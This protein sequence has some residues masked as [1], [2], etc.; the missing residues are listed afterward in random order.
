MFLLTDNNNYSTSPVCL[1]FLQKKGFFK[2]EKNKTIRVHWF[3]RIFIDTSWVGCVRLVRLIMTFLWYQR[4]TIKKS[5]RLCSL[6]DKITSL[7]T[8]IYINWQNNNEMSSDIIVYP[9]TLGIFTFLV[10]FLQFRVFFSSLLPINNR[11]HITRSWS[12][13]SCL[14]TIT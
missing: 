6:S 7:M 11:L 14:I 13:I 8:N 3:H 5:I 1:H 10:F 4:K 12:Y 2:K 9:C